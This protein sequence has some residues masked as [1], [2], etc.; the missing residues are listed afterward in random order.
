MF[1]KRIYNNIIN[2]LLGVFIHMNIKNMLIVAME[3]SAEIIQ[4]CS[5]AIRFGLHNHH[6][7]KNETHENEILIEYYHLQA[8]IEQLQREKIIPT[9][10][11]ERISAIKRDKLRRMRNCENLTKNNKRNNY[12]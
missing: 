3:E 5:K 7:N 9:Y 10:S 1:N 6:P 4:A 2:K 11:E 12:R 8:I